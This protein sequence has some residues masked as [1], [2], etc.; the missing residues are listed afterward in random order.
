M[1]VKNRNKIEPGNEQGV[2]SSSTT[3]PPPPR[4]DFNHW[5]D[6]M[7]GSTSPRFA[8]I[9]EYYTR[10]LHR[11]L[12]RRFLHRSGPAKLSPL[13]YGLPL[14]SCFLS[15]F[16]EILWKH[17][18][19]AYLLT[20]AW[21]RDTFSDQQSL[22]YKRCIHWTTKTLSHGHRSQLIRR[23]ATCIFRA[24]SLVC[25]KYLVLLPRHA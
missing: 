20:N 5:F 21:D 19:S 11:L 22:A 24:S 6:T 8:V 10:F 1:K 4:P 12:R 15:P 13:C 17:Q 3:T 16:Q 18:K 23:P 7:P 2:P 14:L 9:G 25:W